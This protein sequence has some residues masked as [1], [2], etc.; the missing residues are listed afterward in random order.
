MSTGTDSAQSSL[1]SC[2]EVISA[3]DGTLVCGSPSSFCFTNVATDSR[4]V[5]QKTLFIP[6]IGENQDGHAY[7]PQALE[8]GASAVFICKKNYA[9]DKDSFDSLAKKYPAASFIT[10]TNTL[11][12]LQ[13]AAAKY[14]EK[15]P[16]LI[17]IGVTGSSGKT[18]TKEIAAA[19]LSQKY[20]VI[21]N[22]GNL[23]SET[24]LPLSV[25]TIRPEH[26]IGLFEMGMNRVNEMGEIASVL[27][28]QYAVITNIGT[29]HIGILGSRENI[30]AEKAKVF[31]YFGGKGIAI[32]PA[33]DDFT[34]Y[35]AS[36]VDG[37]IVYYGDSVN[38][39]NAPWAKKSI[40]EFVEDKGLEGTSFTVGGKP[41]V[42]PLP[43][44]Y[45]FKNA[46]GAIAL[47]EQLGLS[48]AQI[49]NGI[50]DM[51]PMFG[52]SEVL[53]GK[54]TIVQDCYN[55]N[56]DS[57][58]KAIEFCSSVTVK[59][60]RVY[61]LGDMLELGEDSCEAHH[62]IG[63]LASHGKAK[64]LVFV[65]DE[66][67][68]G[69]KAAIKENLGATVIQISGRNDEAMQKAAE[70]VHAFAREGDMILIKGSRG[71]GLERITTLLEGNNCLD[72]EPAKD[73]L[74]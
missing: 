9:A 67:A 66:M 52:R 30:A 74:K 31:N 23:N 59:G 38:K 22:K 54:Y 58:E 11:S 71:M 42:L 25:F 8:K 43:G 5:V 55:A 65:G 63:V 3:V 41:C 49:V 73:G 7:I 14:V 45:N 4:Q 33:D 17:R 48:P 19:I 47:A 6:L 61:I 64:L 1:L 27:K 13:S 37:K 2:E 60:S 29:A 56:P 69:A 20:T 21:T 39:S 68:E 36:R 32:I 35:L 46:Q 72:D 50:R 28:P 40:V 62:N 34:K 53:N 70:A 18:T 15:F 16:R 51:K 24:G 44:K 26:Q 57:M 10:V 12:A